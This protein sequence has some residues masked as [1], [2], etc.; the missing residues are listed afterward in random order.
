[1]LDDAKFSRQSAFITLSLLVALE[2]YRD[3][4]QVPLLGSAMASRPEREPAIQEHVSM[5][6]R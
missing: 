1:V 2:D 5:P 3:G 4:F 6:V